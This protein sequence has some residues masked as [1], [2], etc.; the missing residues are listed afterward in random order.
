MKYQIEII[1]EEENTKNIWNK[2]TYTNESVEPLTTKVLKEECLKFVN[3]DTERYEKTSDEMWLKNGRSTEACKDDEIF[4][5]IVHERPQY[6]LTV[7]N[8]RQI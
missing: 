3:L 8:K 5:K 2:Q 7:K 6:F 4:D 1:V